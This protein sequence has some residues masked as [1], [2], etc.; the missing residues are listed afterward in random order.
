MS[1]KITEMML[2]EEGI[3]INGNVL[4]DVHVCGLVSANG[5]SYPADVLKN[6][7]TLY[8]KAD[9]YA[10]HKNTRLVEDKIGWLEGIYFVEGKGLYAKKLI[11][12]EAHP[13]YEQTIWWA[14]HNP[15]KIGL[16][17]SVGGTMNKAKT[18]V[19]KIS[20]V[21]SVDLV[22]KPA[23]TGGLREALQEGILADKVKE[24]EDKI[25]LDR[26]IHTAYDIATSTLWTSALSESEKVSRL[27]AVHSELIEELKPKTTKES[28]NMEWDKLT[29]EE[30]EKHAPKLVE[31]IR[32]A[33][34]KTSAETE[35]RVQ[36][37]LNK[38][39]EKARTE[40]FEAQVRA[41]ANDSDKLTKLV[42]SLVEL[43]KGQKVEAPL[44][45]KTKIEESQGG[46]Q[47]TEEE[48]KEETR[49]RLGLTK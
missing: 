48:I 39:P 46:K 11:L 8:E 12:N 10:N 9:V 27:I 47:P 45:P 44:P 34:A 36:E 22:A 30:L 23:T 6:A 41:L 33:A 4:E 18:I 21:E 14:E 20:A 49:K 25:R 1:D 17:H 35:K 26:L 19:E 15:K 13:I 16:S 2:F 37:A 42:E 32:E 28:N 38:L 5:Y 43:G 7:A 3:K 40:I 31:S 24:R 29:V